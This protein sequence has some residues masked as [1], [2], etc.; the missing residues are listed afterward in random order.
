M[1]KVDNSPSKW[2]LFCLQT[3]EVRITSMANNTPNEERPTLQEIASGMAYT[4]EGNPS[5]GDITSGLRRAGID[6]HDAKERMRLLQLI[7]AG[8]YTR[9]VDDAGDFRQE[10]EA[11]LGGNATEAEVLRLAHELRIQRREEER[12]REQ[13]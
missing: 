5:E 10:A 9:K 2:E 13:Q 11:R 12:E 8:D 3:L 7:K 6:P 1:A 4:R